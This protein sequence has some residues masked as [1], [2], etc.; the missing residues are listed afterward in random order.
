[1][2]KPTLARSAED[3][4]ADGAA[5]RLLGYLNRWGSMWSDVVPVD[6]PLLSYQLV[7]GD[8]SLTVNLEIIRPEVDGDRWA[9]SPA[10]SAA[11]LAALVAAAAGGTAAPVGAGSWL[12]V[13]VSA[14]P[15]ASSH[16]VRRELRATLGEHS[17]YSRI[18]VV[19]AD[20]AHVWQAFGP[21]PA[22]VTAPI[23]SFQQSE[24]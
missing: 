11:R 21:A 18:W 7:S 19:G 8:G 17:R 13:D 3:D 12:V 9:G 22:D 23:S 6:R 5:R 20:E 10:Q 15:E 24:P 4:G 16:A 1:M 2:T 14:V